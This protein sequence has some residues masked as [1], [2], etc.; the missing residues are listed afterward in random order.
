MFNSLVKKAPETKTDLCSDYESILEI[1]EADR[2]EDCTGPG[3]L[4]QALGLSNFSVREIRP[5]LGDIIHS[6]IWLLGESL[7][8]Q[9]IK[10]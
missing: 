2:T 1:L 5:L 10:M 9:Q 6:I 4:K 8:R 7:G 3:H